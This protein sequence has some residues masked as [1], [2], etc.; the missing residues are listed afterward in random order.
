MQT[1]I[2]YISVNSSE[3]DQS[4]EFLQ[5]VEDLRAGKLVIFPT[6]TVYGL[7][8][9]INNVEALKGIYMAKGRPS[10]NPLIVHI[11]E[12]DQIWQIIEKDPPKLFW[13]LTEKFWPG[14]VTFIVKKAKTCSDIITGKRESVA[15]RFPSNRIAKR[16]IKLCG[17]PVAAP[18]ANISG[19]PSP[20]RPEHLNE[21]KGRV[22]WIVETQPLEFGIESTII[23]LLNETPVLLRPGPVTVEKLRDLIPDLIIGKDISQAIAPGMQYRHYSPKAEIRLI[24]WQKDKNKFAATGVE[25][26]KALSLNENQKNWALICTDETIHIYQQLNIHCISLGSREDLYRVASNLFHV[27]RTL[28]NLG[29]DCALVEGFEEKGLGITIMDRLKKAA[30]K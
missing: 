1:K 27:L 12:I 30:S 22:Q 2:M 11:G 9:V 21:M 6:E 18:S 28:D 14:P 17:I 19:L 8:A 7:G 10:D 5:C 20:T 3:F 4:E 26:F 25:M 23:S 29:I 15:V 24:P 16:L 13:K